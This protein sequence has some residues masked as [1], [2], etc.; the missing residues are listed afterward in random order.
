ML[1]RKDG[2]RSYVELNA[3]VIVYEG[4]PADLVIIRDINDRKR[5][6]DSLRMSEELYRTIAETSNDLMF[7]IGR[8][9]IVE[10]G[11]KFASEPINKPVDQSIG[12]PRASLFP[13]EVAVNK[14]KAL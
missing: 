6:E 5:A 3:G 11:N 1:K 9:D 8:D 13:P 4:R 10:Y 7:V 2:S 14:K 12:Q